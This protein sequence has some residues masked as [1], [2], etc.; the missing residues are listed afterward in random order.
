MVWTVPRKNLVNVFEYEGSMVKS[1]GLITIS[2]GYIYID[3]VPSVMTR[4]RSMFKSISHSHVRGKYTK[5][6]IKLPETNLNAKDILWLCMRYRVEI[7]NQHKDKLE[8]MTAD[9]DALAAKIQ[10]I[11]TNSKTYEP[12]DSL[13][14]VGKTPRDYQT[15]F[16]NIFNSTHK[17]LNTDEMGMG[18]AQPLSSTVMTPNGPVTMGSLKVGDLVIGMDGKP[19]KILAIHPQ[20]VKSVYKSSFSDGSSTVTCKEHLWSIQSPN[21]KFRKSGFRV[22]ALQDFMSDLKQPNGNSR[23]SVPITEPVEYLSRQLPIKPYSLGVLIGDGSLNNSITVTN[24]SEDIFNKLKDELQ[25]NSVN[26]TRKEVVKDNTYIIKIS[27]SSS[28]VVNEVRDAIRKYSLNCTSYFKYIPDDYKYSS[29]KDRRSILCGL[30]DTDGY[31]DKSGTLQFTS[32]SKRLVQDL[33]EIV[34]SLGGVATLNYK[35]TNIGTN[36]WTSTIKIN[37]DNL[38]YMV[39][40]DKIARLKPLTKYLPVRFFDTVEYVGEQECQ[41]LTVEDEHYLT[42]SYIVT[43]NTLQALMVLAQSQCRPALLVMPTHLI[44]QWKRVIEAVL[45]DA[46]YQEIKTGNPDFKSKE[47]IDFYITTYDKMKK[48]PA[49]YT[50]PALGIKTVVGDEIHHIRNIDTDRRHSFKKIAQE[51][52]Y[53]LGLTGSP[54]FNSGSDLYSIVDALNP[55]ALGKHRDFTSE[56]CEYGG[57]GKYEVSNP[58]VLFDHLIEQGFMVRRMRKQYGHYFNKV[59]PT[60]IPIEASLDDLKEV[61]DVLKALALGS[62]SLDARSAAESARE[63]DIKLRKATGVAK[64]KPV[65]ELVKSLIEEKGKV[66][67]SGWHR[68]FWD[69][70][71]KELKYHNPVM[72]TGSESP[73]EKDKNIKEFCE[74]NSNVLF[75]S[76]KSGEGIDGLQHYCSCIVHGE[77]AWNVM[78]HEQLDMRIDREGQKEIVDIIYP[79]IQDGSDP[80]VLNLHNVKKE[81]SYKLTGMGDELENSSHNEQSPIVDYIKNIAREYLEKNNIEVV[82]KLKASDEERSILDILSTVGFAGSDEMELQNN[83]MLKFNETEH[84]FLVEKEFKFSA[85]SRLDFKLT[86]KTSGNV[87]VIECKSNA[88]NRAE[89]KRQVD[90]YIEEVKP[91]AV[92]VVAPWTGVKDFMSNGVKVFVSNYVV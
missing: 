54:V 23:W 74:G 30:L 11:Y 21:D 22:V 80:M 12:K 41:C 92:I 89:G 36:A 70:L 29:I 86:N 82:E 3:A 13:E 27:R 9:Y 4:I 66:I 79:Y 53:S 60:Y 14:L 17:V 28:G 32:S 73:K 55:D 83:I 71:K 40:K 42:D 20:G 34:Q 91:T 87:Y 1:E 68:D 72:V 18:K 39:K 26:V 7:E 76:H 56:W 57:N 46:K 24:A 90:R 33:I 31:V 8:A 62:L 61:S 69:I 38:V 6:I 49:S 81:I 19:K 75:I 58:E 65:A 16:F 84:N 59:Q 35:R 44:A 88:R 52:P 10:D 47:N 67:V 25:S 63:F 78:T 51:L 45:P 64:A 5:N 15:Q 2:E 50:D 37:H 85:R 43:H 77:L 48:M